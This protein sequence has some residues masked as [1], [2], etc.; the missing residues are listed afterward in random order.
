MIDNKIKSAK[1]AIEDL[2]SDTSVN[3]DETLA[4]LE[5]LQDEIEM[6]INA[7]KESSF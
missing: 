3:L 5:E 7:I 1:E 4:A 2:F 6:K